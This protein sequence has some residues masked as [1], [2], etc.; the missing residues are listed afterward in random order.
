MSIIAIAVLVAVLLPVVRVVMRS[1]GLIGVVAA[2]RVAQQ[3][4]LRRRA[5]DNARAFVISVLIL[6]GLIAALQAYF[7]AAGV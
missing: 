7:V 6:L 3:P 2:V 4:E 5:S 1:L